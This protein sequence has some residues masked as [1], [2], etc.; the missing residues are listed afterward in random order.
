MNSAFTWIKRACLIIG[1]LLLNSCLDVREEFWIHK[2]GSAE[3][4]ITCHMPRTASIPLG[5]PEG[6]KTM[7]EKLLAQED[8]I[9]SYETQVTEEGKRLTLKVRCAV[10]ELMD[11]DKVRQ[12]I[13]RREDLHPAVRKM[14][15]EFNIS[16]EGLS[17]ISVSRR[18][19]PGEA[20]PALSWLPKN[21]TEGHSFVKIMHFPQ[22]IKKHNAHECWDDGCTLMWESSLASAIETPM[23][24]EFVIPYPIPWGWVTSVAI[25]VIAILVGLVLLL[26]KR[27]SKAPN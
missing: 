16:I 11:F 2:D 4:E 14:V 13:Q 19:S 27:L 25:C 15:G 26:R 5:G 12:S 17:G 6:I 3:A 7:A 22:P 8:S 23:V 20:V 10:D 1:V 24:Y 21:Q 18:V 9:D